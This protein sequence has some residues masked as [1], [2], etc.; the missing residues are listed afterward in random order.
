MPSQTLT[1]THHCFQDLI[2]C[3]DVCQ[4]LLSAPSRKACRLVPVSEK[5]VMCLPRCRR[6]KLTCSWKSRLSQPRSPRGHCDFIKDLIGG[7]KWPLL[8]PLTPTASPSFLPSWGEIHITKLTFFFPFGHAHSTR[9]FP[10]QGWNQGTS[11]MN[12]FKTMQ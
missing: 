4:T 5:T 12:H 9:K 3:A 10:G 2:L 6:S 1:L 11:Q 8:S 7:K